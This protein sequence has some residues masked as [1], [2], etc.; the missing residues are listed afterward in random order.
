MDPLREFRLYQASFL[1][2]DYDWDV[3]ALPFLADGNLRTDVDPKRAWAD[4]HLR[5][6]PVEI[7]RADR[8]QLMRI[9]GIGPRY[10]E[11]IMEARRQGRLTDL[12]H[13]RQIGIRAPEQAAPYL[14]LDGKRPPVQMPLL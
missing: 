1:L 13:L 5:H 7:M 14:L 6:N 12:H 2:R 8:A 3:E 10:A 11:A 4:R 9:P